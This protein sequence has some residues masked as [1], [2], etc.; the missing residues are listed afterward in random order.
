MTP[1]IKKA[2]KRL[3]F[4]TSLSIELNHRSITDWIEAEVVGEGARQDVEA[5]GTAKVENAI[6]AEL[7]GHVFGTADFGGSHVE[8][9]EFSEAGRF[10]FQQ[11][12]IAGFFVERANIVAQPVAEVAGGPEDAL[13]EVVALSGQK[14]L[15][16]QLHNEFLAEFSKIAIPRVPLREVDATASTG[17]PRLE[18]T[19]RGHDRLRRRVEDVAV[20]RRRKTCRV[21]NRR[22]FDARQ[23][24]GAAI[25]VAFDFFFQHCLKVATRFIAVDVRQPAMDEDRADVAVLEFDRLLRAAV[26]LGNERP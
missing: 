1:G 16:L 13:R 3:G 7:I 26:K 5:R 9:K 15:A 11:Q 19:L 8:R 25:E 23:E 20:A 10:D 24:V 21:D 6:Q 22:R 2:N 14:A 12:F 18:L 17:Q 4:E